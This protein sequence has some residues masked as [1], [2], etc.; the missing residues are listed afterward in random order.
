MLAFLLLT[1][2]C[3]REK[4]QHRDKRAVTI[5]KMSISIKKALLTR[6]ETLAQHLN[7][8]QEQLVEMAIQQFLSGYSQPDDISIQP[9]R[10]TVDINQGSIYWLEHPTE[11]EPDIAHPHVVVQ[12]NVLNH[13]RLNMVV[14]CALTSNIKRVTIPGNVLLEAGEANLPRQSVVEVS[15]VS[16]VEKSQLGEYIGS[17]T[18]QRINQILE[19][20]RF[21]QVS[22][23]AR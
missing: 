5:T 17:L 15:K 1:V 10:E 19:G 12:G 16:T 2:V 14:V 22:F 8:S 20:I 7:I 13:S 11:E 6:V 18:H 4:H 9:G 21:Q 23:F 3:C